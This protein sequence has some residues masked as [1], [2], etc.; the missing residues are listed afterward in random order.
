MTGRQAPRGLQNPGRKLWDSI[1]DEFQM[2]DADL[3]L[4][5]EACRVRDLVVTLSK[6][7][8]TDGVMAKSSQGVRVHPAVSEVRQQRLVLARLLAT[9]EIPAPEDDNLPAS[10]GVRPLGA[11]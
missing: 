7:I 3:V 9:L 8:E 10:T 11:A 1:T 6:Q 5:E 2:N 4:L